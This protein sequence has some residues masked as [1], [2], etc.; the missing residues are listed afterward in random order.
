MAF[1][2]TI[3]VASIMIGLLLTA[4][5]GTVEPSPPENELPE[6]NLPKLERRAE[7][8]ALQCEQRG[9]E[10]VGDIGD[11]RI[12]RASYV[13][14]SGTK[15]IGTIVYTSEEAVPTEGAVCCN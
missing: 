10:V 15:P 13:C 1:A 3:C 6:S 8:T 7:L 12:H 5:T 2:K 4:C 14:A 9:G 11:G